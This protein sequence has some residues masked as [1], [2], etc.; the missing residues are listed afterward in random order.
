MNLFPYIWKPQPVM[1]NKRST[2]PH[3]RMMWVG[4]KSRRFAAAAWPEQAEDVPCSMYPPPPLYKPKYQINTVPTPTVA[5]TR[6]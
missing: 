1:R 3:F 5:W 6:A 2:V 4:A